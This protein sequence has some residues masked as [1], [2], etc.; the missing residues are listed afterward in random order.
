MTETPTFF[1]SWAFYFLLGCFVGGIIGF[2]GAALLAASGQASRQ[3]EFWE[4]QAKLADC[5][6]K[7]SDYSSKF[8]YPD[9]LEV[10]N[11][12]NPRKA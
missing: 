2:I 10:V 7:K 8:K 1:Q 11:Q 4:M 9:D 6:K 12:G 3:E 5:K